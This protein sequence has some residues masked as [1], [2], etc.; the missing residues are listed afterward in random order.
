MALAESLQP[1][2]QVSRT[3]KIL[4][5]TDMC[6]LAGTVVLCLPACSRAGVA[7]L[8]EHLICNQ[9]VGGSNPSASSN[10]SARTD[11]KWTGGRV[12]NSNRL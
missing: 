9:R 5:Y 6:Q 12:V 8:V 4:C 11:L 7:Q 3:A 2:H 10:R 1:A